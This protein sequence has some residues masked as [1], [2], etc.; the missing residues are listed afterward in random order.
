[1]S[2]DNPFQE[3]DQ[4]VAT[5]FLVDEYATMSKAQ[6]RELI[7]A[8]QDVIPQEIIDHFEAIVH[9]EELMQ[10]EKGDLTNQI[11]EHVQAAKLP[12]KFMDICYFVSAR[13][14]NYTRSPNTVKAWAL[15]ARRFPA[16]VR[17]KYNYED[18]PFA[19][20]AYA[21]KRKFDRIDRDGKH[22]WQKILEYSYEGRNAQSYDV[23]VTQLEEAFEGKVRIAPR[24]QPGDEDVEV[25]VPIVLES[26][27]VEME[28]ANAL[29]ALSQLA[30]RLSGNPQIVSLIEQGLKLLRI[31]LDQ[32]S[33]EKKL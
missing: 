33:G 8:V 21:A 20:F 30:R 7:Y 1:V 24:Y 11:W 6:T 10:W 12:Y 23:S 32:L 25:P 2:N 4:D 9:F 16:P 5:I 29:A 28:F 17:E 22:T 27:S 26:H 3:I 13:F 14:L 18:V 15:T 19:H 31:A